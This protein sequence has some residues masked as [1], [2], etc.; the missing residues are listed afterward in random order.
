MRNKRHHPASESLWTQRQYSGRLYPL[1]RLL[2]E[3]QKK[4]VL[5]KSK[6]R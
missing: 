5:K 3:H 2:S 6:G 1:Q 4:N